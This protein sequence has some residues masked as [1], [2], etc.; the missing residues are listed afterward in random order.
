P[1]AGGL[2]ALLLAT[3]PAF[4]SFSRSSLSDLSGAAAAVLAFVLV[5]IGLRRKRRWPI[6]CAAVILGLSLCI[7]PQLVFFAPVLIAM[8][9]FPGDHSWSR[10]LISCS[11][12]LAAFAIACLPY[13]L[14]NTFEFGHPLRTG[15]DFWVPASMEGGRLFSV[16][17]MPSQLSM[18]WSEV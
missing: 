4:T 7:R 10:W 16:H 13:L 5:Y 9:L 1:L 12:T 8:A 15:Y 17:N 6:Y 11:L 2:A 18:L 14:F 3:Q